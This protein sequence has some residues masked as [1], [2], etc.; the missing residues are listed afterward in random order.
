MALIKFGLVVVD[1]RGKLGGHVFTKSRKG[2]TIRTKVTPANPQTAAQAIARQ[3]LGSLSSQWNALSEEK[4]AGWNSATKN[5]LKTNI[6]GDVKE[7]AGRDLFV[8]LN[9]NL[10]LVGQPVITDAP[11]PEEIPSFSLSSTEF[12]LN[13]AVGI[14][15]D[16]LQPIAPA[17]HSYVFW[18]TPPSAGVPYFLM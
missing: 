1:A 12:D 2:A 17:G 18:A 16:E 10:Q 7:P 4:R 11:S 6:F 8:K 9:A 14:V 13:P 5:F 15:F 3:R